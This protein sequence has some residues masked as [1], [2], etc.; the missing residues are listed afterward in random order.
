MD[1]LQRSKEYVQALSK[2]SEEE[3]ATLERK[4]KDFEFSE[5][6]PS[7]VEIFKNIKILNDNPDFWE[8]SV[9]DKGKHPF[10]QTYA[11][12]SDFS[13]Y[14]KNILTFNPRKPP[15]IRTMSGQKEDIDLMHEAIKENDHGKYQQVIINIIKGSYQGLNRSLILPLGDFM[16]EKSGKPKKDPDIQQLEE[17][18]KIAVAASGAP[19]STRAEV[20]AKKAEAAV[21]ITEAAAKKAEAAK[22]T[23]KDKAAGEG[24]SEFEKV[25]TDQA[26]KDK[27]AATWWLIISGLAVVVIIWILFDIFDKSVIEIA[28]F[29]RFLQ[30]FLSK[31]FLL[32]FL[33]VVF[34]QLVRNYNTRMHQYT[35][36]K[37]RS[38]SLKCFG[39]LLESAG[40]TARDT[41]LIKATNMIFDVTN[42]GYISFK[43]KESNN[44]PSMRTTSSPQESA[45]A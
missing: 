5:I 10:N 37:H 41:V 4:G 30:L 27:K 19:A 9:D 8:Q 13:Q 26:K 40:E 3:I 42:T 32:S 18:R 7:I 33:S 1:S 38:N 24:V 14:I 44:V 36:N 20:A 28:D 39:V 15:H 22:K 12:L 6:Y 23:I 17:T 45:D 25:F 34:Y 16:L 11:Y 35:L 29:E 43:G 2:W 21:E 31:L